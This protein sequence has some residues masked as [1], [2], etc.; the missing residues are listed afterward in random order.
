MTNSKKSKS[1][2]LVGLLAAT[3]SSPI[4]LAEEQENAF[5]LNREEREVLDKSSD[6]HRVNILR[7]LYRDTSQS[8]QMQF[9]TSYMINEPMTMYQ[10][11]NLSHPYLINLRSQQTEREISDIEKSIEN[12][13]SREHRNQAIFNTALKYGMEAGLYYT[14]RTVFNTLKGPL[15][16]QM[17]ETYPYHALMLD[18]GKVKPPVIERV[19][20]SRE[21]EDRRTMRDRKARYRIVE[22]SE[23][24]NTT[25][26]F[27]DHF[28]NLLLAHPTDPHLF[29][30]PI[31][32]EE[33]RQWRRGALNGWIQGVKMARQIVTENMRANHRTFHGYLTYHQLADAQIVTRPTSENTNVGTTSRGDILNIGESVFEITRLP[34]LSGDS[35][36]WL[37]LTPVD[38]IFGELTVDEVN[39]L[40]R[41]IE[42]LTTIMISYDEESE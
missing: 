22:Q 13:D 6:H 15:Y 29:L 8:G 7:N 5:E 20:F 36:E 18:N 10:V 35:Q 42:D 23:V 30:L 33:M 11:A 19:G 39:R 38:D 26:T 40:T 27:L 3:L 28:Q 37:A 14:G 31:D 32:E 21:I 9:D 41:E 1:I 34:Q 25:P 2:T 4:A 17:S 16:H 12:D 24:T